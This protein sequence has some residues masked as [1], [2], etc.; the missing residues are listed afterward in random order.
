MTAKVGDTV[1][2]NFPAATAGTV[3]DL[4]IDQA[5]RG[6]DQRR[7]AA[8]AR[9]HLPHRV[10]GRPVDHRVVDRPATYTFIC[11]IHAHKGATELGGHGRQG[12][13]HLRRRPRRRA[14]GVDYTEYRVNRR[15]DGPRRPTQATRVAVRDHVQ[16]PRPGRTWSSTARRTRPATSRR[17][18]RW[19]SRS[20]TP[21]DSASAGRE[22][23]RDVPRSMGI[24]LGGT[25]TFG[26][27]SRAWRRTT[28]PPRR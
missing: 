10:A 22:R 18:S 12:H 19:R 1:R 14:P 20:R 21:A 24:S 11:K 28:T 2:W 5:G 23:D 27:S 17:P 8:G 7:H 3:H 13:R 15:G 9:R 16:R 4:W 26:R 6:A 25:V